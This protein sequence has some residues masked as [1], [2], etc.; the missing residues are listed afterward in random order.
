MDMLV[1]FLIARLAEDEAWA[2]DSAGPLYAD[3]EP[4]T[5]GHSARVLADVKAKLVI[6]NYLDVV[7]RGADAR[8][9]R[10]EDAKLTLLQL[11]S[12]YADHP[13]FDPSWR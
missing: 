9:W 4:D 6:V 10:A 8:D 3:G 5:P 2:L 11:A 1:L 7:L 12:V 13:D